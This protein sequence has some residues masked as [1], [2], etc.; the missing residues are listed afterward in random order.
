MSVCI[1]CTYCICSRGVKLDRLPTQKRER[2]WFFIHEHYILAAGPVRAGERKRRRSTTNNFFITR[3]W[4]GRVHVYKH[5]SFSLLPKS[6]GDWNSIK[7]CSCDVLVPFSCYRQHDIVITSI[8]VSLSGNC[9][10]NDR[11]GKLTS[12]A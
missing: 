12:I 2:N 10:M 1:L 9:P 6:F 11:K 7:A 8:A 3:R 4:K 5:I